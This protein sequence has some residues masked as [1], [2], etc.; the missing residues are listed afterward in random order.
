M[1][2]RV[3]TDLENGYVERADGTLLPI[4]AML[5][6]TSHETEVAE[7]AVL[8]VSGTTERGFIVTTVNG[9]RLVECDA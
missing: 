5:D 9:A 8:V 6:A 7:E 3:W 2:E 4:V 1:T